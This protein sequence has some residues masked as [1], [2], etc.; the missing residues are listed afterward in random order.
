VNRISQ[1]DAFFD[2]LYEI[3]RKDRDIILV[4]ADMG[5]PSLD[6]FRKD[7]ASQYLCVGIAEQSMITVATGLA[8]SGKRVFTYAIMPF[9]TLRCYEITRVD[10]S[11][12]NLPITIIGVGA[13]FSYDDSGPTHHST[14]DITAM[15]ALPNMTL[16]NASDSTMAAAFADLSYQASGPSYV[17]LDRQ[18]LPTIYGQR[19]DFTGGSIQHKTGKDITIIAT[20]NMVHNA[21]EIAGKLEEQSI[22]TG[23]IDLYRLKPINAELLLQQIGDS[24]RIA[25]IEEHFLDG[26]MGSAVIEVLIDNDMAIPV[27]RFGIQNK[28]Y[29]AYGGRSNIQS[30]CGLDVSSVTQSILGWG[31]PTES[32]ELKITR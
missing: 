7:L 4:S 23:V 11:I 29:Y 9:A 15:R 17:R 25:T 6:K 2:R 30:L 5:A 20:G 24:Q 13:G 8:L 26:G 10:L 1:R 32:E 16:L 3:A 22:Q 14:E 21:F 28:Y 12:M 19:T 31:I 18:V 27:K